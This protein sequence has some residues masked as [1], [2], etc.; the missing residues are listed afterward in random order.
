M[1][2]IGLF[3]RGGRVPISFFFEKPNETISSFRSAFQST[4][5]Q[6]AGEV[7]FVLG[8]AD[9]FNSKIPRNSRGKFLLIRVLCK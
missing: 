4:L 6:H 8:N 9:I 2:L 7:F 3:K 1:K 5:L